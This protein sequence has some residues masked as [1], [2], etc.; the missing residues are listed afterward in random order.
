MSVFSLLSHL[1]TCIIVNEIDLIKKEF[2]KKIGL[3]RAGSLQFL[4]CTE[5]DT[6]RR[7]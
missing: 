3:K 5:K 6:K 1:N 7:L 2:I 4:S